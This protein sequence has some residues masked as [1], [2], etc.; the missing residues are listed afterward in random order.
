MEGRRKRGAPTRVWGGILGLAR[1]IPQKDARKLIWAQLT[2][3]DRE[4]VRCAHNSRRRPQLP[5]RYY[6][7]LV[8]RGHWAVLEWLRP[9]AICPAGAVERAFSMAIDYV[10]LAALQW[11]TRTER[12][13]HDFLFRMMAI[14]IA[15]SHVP[16]LEW[17]QS[18]GTYNVGRYHAISLAGVIGLVPPSVQA[19]W[20][21]REKQKP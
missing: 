18:S 9:R 6:E 14:C 20:A 3:E 15:R 7:H 16:I 17:M 2:A 21:A 10:D 1:S 19:W 4:M 11:I 8:L 5:L 12:L 13:E